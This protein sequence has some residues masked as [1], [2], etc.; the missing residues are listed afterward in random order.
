MKEKTKRILVVLVKWRHSANG[1]FSHSF[2]LESSSVSFLIEIS[3]A[4]NSTLRFWLFKAILIKE[5]LELVCGVPIADGSPFVWTKRKETL[6]NFLLKNFFGRVYSPRLT[7]GNSAKIYRYLSNKPGGGGEG[8]GVRLICPA[9]V[10]CLMHDIRNRKVPSII[11]NLFSD[12]TSI[13]SYMIS[14]S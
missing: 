7:T 2:H 13:H 5:A 6:W 11:L 8:G 4:R 9:G 3:R 1:L 14:I 10:C 12:T